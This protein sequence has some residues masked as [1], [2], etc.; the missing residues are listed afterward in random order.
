MGKGRASEKILSVTYNCSFKGGENGAINL[1]AFIHPIGG[2]LPLGA[3]T[4]CAVHYIS[5]SRGFIGSSWAEELRGAACAF[6]V[7][8]LLICQGSKS[9]AGREELKKGPQSICYTF[10]STVSLFLQTQEFL[11]NPPH[12]ALLL[13]TYG[14][15]LLTALSPELGSELLEGVL[16]GETLVPISVPQMFVK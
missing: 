7:A 14:D 3:L 10:F 12:F 15:C 9:E 11:Q 2:R 13:R 16:L 4:S 1:P 8:E 5:R 6:K